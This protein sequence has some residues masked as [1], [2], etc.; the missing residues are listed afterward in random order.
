MKLW[1]RFIVIMAGLLAIV[2]FASVGTQNAFAQIDTLMHTED[3]SSSSPWGPSGWNG[4]FGYEYNYPG[5]FFWNSAGNGGYNGSCVGDVWDFCSPITTPSVDASTYTASADSV[6]VDFDFYWEYNAY[7]ASYGDDGFE[8]DANNTSIFTGTTTQL[9]TYYNPT[10]YSWDYIQTD[11]MYWTHYHILIPASERTSGLTVTFKANPNWGASDF[12]IDNVKITAYSLPPGLLSLLPKSLNFGTATPNTPDTL[13]VTAYNVG[14]APLHI[15]G[16]SLNGSTAFSMVNAP[17][18]GDSIMPGASTQ[19]C[20]QFLPLNAGQLTGTFS[21]STDAPDSATQSVTL[22]GYGA[23]PEVTYGA[24]TL[25]HR[26]ATMLSDSSQTEY[27]PVT[28]S[29]GAPLAFNS[30]YFIGMNSN[31]YI[32]THY[33][34]NP[35][36]PDAVDSIGVEFVPTIEGRPD[37]SLVVS[38]NAINNPSD[39][40]SLFGVGTLPHLVITVDSPGV[41][42]TVMFDSV[43]IGDS[44]CQTV[45][46]TN[47]GTDTLQI[48]KQVVT[49]GDYDFTYQPL[50]GMDTVILPGGGTQLATVCFKP[51][52][53]GDRFATIRLFTNIPR[54]FE[55]PSRDTGEF[56]INVTGIGVP[57]GHLA[58]AGTLTDTAV[59]GKTNCI[60]DTLMNNGQA[61]LTITSAVLSGPNDTAFT[62]SG[63]ALPTTLS[64]GQMQVVSLCFAPTAIGTHFDTLT[65][66]GS[67]SERSL[68]QALLLQGTGVINCVSADSVVVFG[69]DSMTLVGASDTSCVTVTNCGDLAAKYTASAPVGTGYTLLPPALSTA[70]VQPGQSTQFCVVFTPTALGASNGTITIT[71]GPNAVTTQLAGVG[72]GVIA[73]ASGMPQLPVTIGMCDTF[74]VSVHNSGNVAW[75][76]GMGHIGGADSA[77]FAIVSE[78]TPTAIAPGDSAQMTISFCPTKSG[79]ETMTLTFPSAAP[80]PITAFSYMVSASGTTEGVTLKS[81]QDGFELG[82]SYPNPTNGTADI[83]VTLPMASH[84]RV[85]ILNATG[86]LVRTAFTGMLSAGTQNISLDAKGL[87]SGTYFYMLTT[88]NIQLTRQLSLIK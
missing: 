52:R 53:S 2:L 26:V 65:V 64:P 34:Q 55:K 54:T 31:N 16:Y 13:C 59:V 80:A 74:Q 24:T 42:N 58:I 3:F 56:D 40:V 28:S 79:T 67:T 63:P 8:L 21:L 86:E 83:P 45:T 20:F 37:A 9:N 35:L 82:Q 15:T 14:V 46:L 6:W 77:D 50:T 32:I 85:D 71:G 41:G 73:S 5:Q 30:I 19:Y 23:V 38:T 62:L 49:Y 68:T 84:V 22:T 29:G 27:L 66:Q 39:T 17:V 88:G 36:P 12:A 1:N 78:A 18:V 43:A 44:V 81:S 47:P 61:D 70:E 48:L 75:T 57:Y 10:D 87:P 4:A 33:P 60:T 7:D 69:A 25:F 72:A 76:P 11:P 51:L